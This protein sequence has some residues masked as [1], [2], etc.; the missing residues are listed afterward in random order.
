MAHPESLYFCMMEYKNHATIKGHPDYVHQPMFLLANG[1]GDPKHDLLIPQHHGNSGQGG[2]SIDG[3]GFSR[4]V[5]GVN[6]QC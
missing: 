5:A 6:R 1:T 4:Q 2:Q 3:G